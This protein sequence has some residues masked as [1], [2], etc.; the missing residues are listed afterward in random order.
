VWFLGATIFLAGA[1]Y[2]LRGPFVWGH[3]GY[4]AGEYAT[5]ARHTLTNG[6]ILPGNVPGTSP[7]RP[8][9]YYLHHPIL[10]HQLVTLTFGL[11]GDTES[12]VRL[13]GL[14]GC[15]ATLVLLSLFIARH[16]GPW[17]GAAAFVLSAVVPFNL[18]YAPHIDPGFPGLACLMAAALGYGEW[19]ARGRRRAA[20][21]TLAGL[22]LAGTFDWTPF[23][24]AVPWGVHVLAVA[25]SRRGRY[26]AFVPAFVVAVLLPAGLH[27][28]AVHEAQQWDDLFGAY[29]Q[30]SAVMPL[31]AF[32]GHMKGYLEELFGV[33]F[34][35]LG[36]L[37]FLFAAADLVRGR[38]AARS[39]LLVAL[40][41]AITVHVLI[42]RLEVVTH[43][44]RL[45]YLAPAVVLGSIETLWRL[46]RLVRAR[47]GE[48]AALLAGALVTC[49]LI[50]FTLPTSWQGL[51]DSRAHSGIPGWKTLD[52]SL[53]RAWLARTLSAETT[54]T[55]VLYLHPSIPFRMEIGFYLK[56]DFVPAV[57][58]TVATLAPADQKHAVF[59]FVTAALPPTEWTVVSALARAHPYARY[60][61]FGMLDLR[62]QRP[63]L[64]DAELVFPDPGAR[65]LWRRYWEGPYLWPSLVPD[66]LAAVRQA[67]AFGLPRE[68][69]DG[70][71]PAWPAPPA[72]DA[73]ALVQARNFHA[74]ASQATAARKDEESLRALFPVASLP[75][76]RGSEVA[77]D[78]ERPAQRSAAPLAEVRARRSSPLM[79]ELLAEVAVEDARYVAYVRKQ[80]ETAWRP[81]PTPAPPPAGRHAG[82]WMWEALP[83]PPPDGMK[84]I[85]VALFGE[86]VGPEKSHPPFATLALPG[87]FNGREGP[88]P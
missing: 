22:A 30:R 74:W 37:G 42:F 70:P 19:L 87:T 75:A 73:G 33:P 58:A 29:H 78:E 46:T 64:E 84:P 65:S 27:A 54:P 68:A 9:T 47:A 71:L 21:V 35:A 49:G 28:L 86:G 85:T 40:V 23:L 43:A 31:A 2:G 83:L 53:P 88:S 82:Q 80:G 72:T 66:Q 79:V 62:V 26:L 52:P 69:I 17:F 10:T 7:P 1:G 11:F 38:H 36:A 32:L 48:G 25:W 13:A 81:L 14:L 16:H 41:V 3:F 45:I 4:H 15:A 18:W 39:L 77:R 6:S 60:G 67:L 51:L 24:F 56:R 34:L 61:P 12:S 44:Y 20:L 8:G 55:D 76:P 5:R 57:A 59:A 50:A 63:H